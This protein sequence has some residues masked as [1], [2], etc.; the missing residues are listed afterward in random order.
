MVNRWKYALAIGSWV[1]IFAMGC[2]ALESEPGGE[3]SSSQSANDGIKRE[4]VLGPVRAE[5]QFFPENPVL[6]EQ[7]TLVVAVDAPAQI[8]VMMPEFGDQLGRFG[9]ADFKETQDI[10]S[11]GRMVY[12]QRYTLDLPMSGRL[13][14]PGFLIEFVDNRPDSESSGK[15]QELLTEEMS[16]EVASVLPEG[17]VLTSLYGP[18][19]PLPELVLPQANR[20]LRWWMW[21]IAVVCLGLVVGAIVWMRRRRVADIVLPPEVVALSA[22]D[23]LRS[24]PMPASPEAIDAWYVSLSGIIRTYVEARFSLHAPRLTTEEFF[25][26]AG[27]SDALSAQEKAMIHNLL[28]SADRVKFTEYVPATEASLQILEGAYQFVEAT[29]VKPAEAEG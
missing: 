26:L 24:Q 23:F 16:F 2:G 19:G 29:R 12:R 14:V 4:T 11:D 8:S 15:V 3:A 9:I 22:L 1:G 10:S 21:A 17:Q 27:R 25:E 18:Q 6:G 5:V 13:R 7:V 28:A 20:G